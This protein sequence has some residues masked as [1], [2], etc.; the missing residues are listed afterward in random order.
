MTAFMFVRVYDFVCAWVCQ[1]VQK[2]PHVA[3]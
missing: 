1:Y 2:E 3:F